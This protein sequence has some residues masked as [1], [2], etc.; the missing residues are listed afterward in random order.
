[1]VATNIAEVKGA[2][3]ASGGENNPLVE[4]TGAAIDRIRS[5]LS[6]LDSNDE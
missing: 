1:M 6:S 4:D 3:M 5:K 2:E